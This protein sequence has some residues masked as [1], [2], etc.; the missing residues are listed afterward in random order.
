MF[1]PF[2]KI[3]RTRARDHNGSTNPDLALRQTV[4]GFLSDP[5][6]LLVDPDSVYPPIG[7]QVPDFEVRTWQ[8]PKHHA[9][10]ARLRAWDRMRA[11]PFPFL[12]RPRNSAPNN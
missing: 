2:S 4:A 7:F 3:F 1:E 12:V 10:P 11:L 8:G 9:T 5:A 6:P